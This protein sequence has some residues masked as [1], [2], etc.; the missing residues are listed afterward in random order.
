MFLNIIPLFILRPSIIF[1][2]HPEAHGSAFT[3]FSF[4]TCVA[5]NVNGSLQEP[6]SPLDLHTKHLRRKPNLKNRIINYYYKN[7]M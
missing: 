3:P 4:S 7:T 1:A 5:L 6:R 2:H